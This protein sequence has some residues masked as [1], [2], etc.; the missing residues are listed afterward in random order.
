MGVFFLNQFQIHLVLSLTTTGFVIR[1]I[2]DTPWLR[3]ASNMSN[4]ADLCPL[5]YS[6]VKVSSE[7]KGFVASALSAYSPDAVGW[8]S[9]ANE[10]CDT[11]TLVLKIQLNNNEKCMIHAIEI[12][13]H[14]AWDTFNHLF[15]PLLPLLL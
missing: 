7:E 10:R 13:S 6:V 15:A 9:S 3:K 1:I 5:P 14:G 11:Q 2:I 8:Q 4:V 12:I